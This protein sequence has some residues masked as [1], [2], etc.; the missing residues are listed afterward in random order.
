MF[1]RLWVSAAYVESYKHPQLSASMRDL[2]VLHEQCSLQGI[3]V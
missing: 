1:S 2:D 3:Y